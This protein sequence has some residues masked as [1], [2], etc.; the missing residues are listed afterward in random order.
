MNHNRHCK[1]LPQKQSFRICPMAAFLFSGCIMRAPENII[2]LKTGQKHRLFSRAFTLLQICCNFVA[3][4]RGKM[5][6]CFCYNAVRN[7]AKAILQ[8]CNERTEETR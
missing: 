1:K 6:L 3:F 7:Q 4:S 5:F 2:F 8:S